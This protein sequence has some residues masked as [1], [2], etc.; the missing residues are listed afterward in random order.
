LEFA[1]DRPRFRLLGDSINMPLTYG[2]IEI[3]QFEVWPFK[4]TNFLFDIFRFL[5]MNKICLYC[6]VM[7]LIVKG[8]GTF[9]S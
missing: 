9:K 5:L 2:S 4:A 1:S 3:V 6:S 8:G 7:S